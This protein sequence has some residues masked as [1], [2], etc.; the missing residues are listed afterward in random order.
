MRIEHLAMTR[1]RQV[2][3][4]LTAW[5]ERC[6]EIIC[7]ETQDVMH[8]ELARPITFHQAYLHAVCVARYLHASML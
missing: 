6:N 8:A 7:E 1:E 2:A 3:D 4:E 5:N